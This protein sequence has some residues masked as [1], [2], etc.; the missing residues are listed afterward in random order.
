MHENRAK[1]WVPLGLAT[2]ALAWLAL[3]LGGPGDS[4]PLPHPPAN[5]APAARSS[6]PTASPVPES[7]RS[8]ATP[9]PRAPAD[10]VLAAPPVARVTPVELEVRVQE[11]TLGGDAPVPN[12]RVHVQLYAPG[13]ED[14]RSPTE[15]V[16]TRTNDE[17]L[18]P[19]T[20][21]A[22]GRV[23]VSA[24]TDDQSAQVRAFVPEGGAHRVEVLLED[25]AV[26]SG[27]VLDAV[28]GEPIAGARVTFVRR[29]AAGLEP[30][31]TD[32]RGLF[33]VGS[34]QVDMFQTLEVSAP[35][36]GF[37]F[38][39][40]VVNRDGSWLAPARFGVPE[41]A[42]EVEPFLKIRLVPE[43]TVS[44]VVVDERGAPVP[45]ARVEALGLL[46]IA[47]NGVQP[48]ESSTATGSRGEFLLSGLRSDLTHAVGVQ[49][50]ARRTTLVST[51]G[52]VSELGE[53]RLG[54][55]IELR[56]SI[57]DRWGAPAVGAI[58]ELSEIA[59]TDRE[60]DLSTDGG[61][62]PLRDAWSTQPLFHWETATDE[63]GVFAFEGVSTGR[64]RLVAR[65]R[66]FRSYRRDV[67]V[68]SSAV[69]EPFV[70]DERLEVLRGRVTRSGSPLGGLRITVSDLGG[71]V[72]AVAR[73]G[74][75]GRYRLTGLRKQDDYVM[76]V[77]AT[78]SGDRS[79]V[80]LHQSRWV[81]THLER[82]LEL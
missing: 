63:T 9:A 22:A 18:A 31:T 64:F 23:V 72:L 41:V 5:E 66:P 37:E 57:V 43:K 50:G 38:A 54:Q 80:L 44:G 55:D 40:L 16:T 78:A 13:N 35:G 46:L 36:Y 6:A 70:L 26:V 77:H 30:I 11:R 75:D 79:E 48:D 8:P 62:N 28:D 47:E 81:F 14:P 60:V 15:R 74:A 21:G 2:L 65:P 52:L 82:D 56:G 24:T 76:S 58:V 4:P 17:G 45:E 33:E 12:A 25:A 67:E 53:I 69:L 73:T 1:L 39:D 68:T 29:A 32:A 10:S 42:G 34:W 3:D 20:L 49:A 19:V 27:R 59:P 51:P 7:E 71:K 61:A